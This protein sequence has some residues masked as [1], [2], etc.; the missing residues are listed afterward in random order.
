MRFFGTVLG[1]LQVN[2]QAGCVCSLHAP[3]EAND[4]FSVDQCLNPTKYTTRLYTLCVYVQWHIFH[5]SDYTAYTKSTLYGASFIQ[6]W[7]YTIA[8]WPSWLVWLLQ[9]GVNK[10]IDLP[11][12]RSHFNDFFSRRGLSCMTLLY[13]QRKIL[14]CPPPTH[15]QK[16]WI[17]FNMLKTNNFFFSFERYFIAHS[18]HKQIII[19]EW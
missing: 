12:T 9:L 4:L 11:Q 19:K 7:R 18:M 1:Y 15:T 14:F 2:F 17:K 5:C 16:K 10:T 13:N 3:A 8:I 6:S